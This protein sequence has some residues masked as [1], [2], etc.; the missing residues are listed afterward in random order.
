MTFVGLNEYQVRANSIAVLML[1]AQ[2]RPLTSL[3]ATLRAN[4]G[5][6]NFTYEM[7][8]ASDTGNFLSG[9]SLTVGYDS[10]LGPIQIS[11]MYS[12]QTKDFTGYVNIGFHF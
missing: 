1:G 7:P 6:Y 10:G 8:D 11:G 5:A 4:V 3:Y 2:Y 12:D 9:Y